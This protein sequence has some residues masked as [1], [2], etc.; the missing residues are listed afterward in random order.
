MNNDLKSKRFTHSKDY[1]D[2]LVDSLKNT[3]YKSLDNYTG[4][5]EYKGNIKIEGLGT[6]KSY[7]THKKYMTTPTG[8]ELFKYI[9]VDDNGGYMT[10]DNMKNS[11]PDNKAIE[12]YNKFRMGS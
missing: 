11:K 3:T 4:V 1:L 6:I 2:K 10:I 7:D 8:D 12:N 5:G 9:N